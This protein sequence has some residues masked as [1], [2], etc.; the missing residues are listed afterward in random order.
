MRSILDAA[1]VLDSPL[2]ALQRSNEDSI[3]T[4]FLNFYSDGVLFQEN[5]RLSKSNFF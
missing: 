5:W 2:Q 3:K 1:A 4:E